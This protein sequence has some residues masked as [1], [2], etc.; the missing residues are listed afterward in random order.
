MYRDIR[1]RQSKC[2]HTLLTLSTI[3]RRQF[4]AH[5]CQL[6]LIDQVIVAF[7]ILFYGN[8]CHSENVLIF[9]PEEV[10]EIEQHIPLPVALKLVYPETRNEVKHADVITLDT[11]ETVPTFPKEKFVEKRR[12]RLFLSRIFARLPHIPVN[13]SLTSSDCGS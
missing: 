9:N 1:K 2:A 13:L 4:L 11:L 5:E 6:F 8:G 3:P 10:S 7:V 12:R